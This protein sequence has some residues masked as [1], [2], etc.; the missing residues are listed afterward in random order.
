VIAGHEHRPRRRFA[1]LR[2]RRLQRVEIVRDI[3][4]DDEHIDGQLANARAH[5]RNDLGMMIHVQ[6]A[7]QGQAHH[8]IM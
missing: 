4:G 7:G 3:A 5:E 6:V 1:E 8:I 2:Q